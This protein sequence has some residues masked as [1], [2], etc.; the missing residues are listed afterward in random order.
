M[1]E[2]VPSAF[3]I[4]ASQFQSNDVISTTRE[5][6]DIVWNFLLPRGESHLAGHDELTDLLM[7]TNKDLVSSK[8]HVFEFLD[9]IDQVNLQAGRMQRGT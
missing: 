2:Q 8:N 3:Q 5:P 9:R 1:P 6:I 7:R 4:F